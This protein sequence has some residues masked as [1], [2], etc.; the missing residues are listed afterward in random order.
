[1]ENVK[2]K[3]RGRFHQAAFYLTLISTILYLICWMFTKGNT[4]IVIYLLSQ[5]ILFGISYKYHTTVW[6]NH[7]IERIFQLLDHISIFILISGTQTSVALTLLPSSRYTRYLLTLTWSITVGG[8][9]KIVLMQ[10]LHHVFDLCV[11]IL[12]GISVVPFFKILIDN[13]S[14]VDLILFIC[15]G[16]IYVAGGIIFGIEKPNPIPHIFG[17]H[18]VFHVFTVVANY[19]FFIPILKN[20]IQSLDIKIFL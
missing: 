14:P 15:G 11:Y 13:L 5:L 6:K 7:R 3:L 8:I 2:P 17:Y 20:Y 18:E 4:G 19:C 12:H 16:S 1:M 9:L 10:K